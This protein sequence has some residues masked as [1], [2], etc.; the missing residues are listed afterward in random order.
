[1]KMEATL[2]SN[3]IHVA[4]ENRQFRALLLPV[5]SGKTAGESTLTERVIRLAYANPELRKIVL[6]S[7]KVALDPSYGQAKKPSDK[8]K[9]HRKKQ[10][11]R[12]DDSNSIN[13]VLDMKEKLI[14]HYGKSY[15]VKWDHESSRG[16]DIALSTLIGYATSAEYMQSGGVGPD[17]K[18]ILDDLNKKIK[19]DKAKKFIGK[20]AKGA[21]KETSRALAVGTKTVLKGVGSMMEGLG[22]AVLSK[23]DG[24]GAILSKSCAVA[25]D[26]VKGDKGSDI[27]NNMEKSFSNIMSGSA[28]HKGLAVGTFAMKQVGLA[29]AKSLGGALGKGAKYANNFLGE[30]ITRTGASLIGGAVGGAFKGI[31]KV[32]NGLA[33]TDN[34]SIG[35]SKHDG[36]ADKAERGVS[37]GLSKAKKFLSR[38]ASEEE[39]DLLLN[40]I[41]DYLG[42][43]DEDTLQAMLPYM[44]ENG[45]VDVEKLEKD[46][47]DQGEALTKDIEEQ[48]A[49]IEKEDSEKGKKEEEAKKKEEEAKKKEEKA[50]KAEAKKKEMKDN[51]VAKKAVVKMA[52]ENPK[53]RPQILQVVKLAY[54]N[55]KYRPQIFQLALNVIIKGE[56]KLASGKSFEEAV[57]GEKFKHPETGNQVSFGSLP[58]KDQSKIRSEFKSKTDVPK[59]SD[60]GVVEAKKLTEKGKSL[61]KKIDSADLDSMSEEDLMGLMDEIKGHSS[62]VD[63]TYKKSQKDLEAKE[64]GLKNMESKIE[65]LYSKGK[66]DEA[67]NLEEKMDS[68][69]EILDTQK[70]EAEK[71]MGEMSTADTESSKKLKDIQNKLKEKAPKKKKESK[72]NF[73]SK[74]AMVKMA[75]ENPKYRPQILQLLQ[76]PRTHYAIADIREIISNS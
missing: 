52:Y 1:M 12:R 20:F 49:K 16:D 44:D 48:I 4:H 64:Q 19:S 37:K 7:I 73:V 57:K 11:K 60:N 47:K 34:V 18:K 31:G 17:A 45:K 3:L 66:T 6:P 53:Y 21:L 39:V 65:S 24:P 62:E 54:E 32:A 30:S 46:I 55:P 72:D 36:L 76:V 23:V 13:A 27:V 28:D 2:R 75:Y 8:A 58:S 9:S 59:D 35:G 42:Q 25:S 14:E 74:K 67:E 38:K 50:K 43:I 41:S 63:A 61:L 10:Q 69:R 26:A 33:A 22:D 71:S 68:G 29:G 51:F 40:S 15:R 5:L 70:K 56:Q